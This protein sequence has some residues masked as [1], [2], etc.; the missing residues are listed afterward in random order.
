MG[1]KHRVAKAVV[2]SRPYHL[3]ERTF[4]QFHYASIGAF[5]HEYSRSCRDV[6]FVQVGANDG[7]TW[8]PYHPFIVRDRWKGIVIE[9]QRNIFQE[10]L[11][12]TYR[13]VP[14]VELLNVAIDTVDGV[15]P[16]YKYAF[17][18]SRWASGLASFDRHNLIDNF[19]TDY[20]QSNIR[21]EGL[22]VSSD[23]ERYLTSEDVRCVTFATLIAEHRISEI[24]FLITDA[25]RFDIP[26]LE[27]FPLDTLRPRNIIFELLTPM[28]PSFL[29]FF[30]KLLHHGYRLLLDGS[31]C[32]AVLG[33]D[34]RQ[35]TGY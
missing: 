23:P 5:I 12:R 13:N 11:I 21:R 25:E 2:Q 26:I 1:L 18:T 14:G 8:D 27:T 28:D 16:L 3:Y 33:G 22:Q 31:D 10:R 20:I 24:D 29:A 7:V 34:E 32:I 9:P 19:G 35:R 17:T 4:G 6:F 30:N 15:R